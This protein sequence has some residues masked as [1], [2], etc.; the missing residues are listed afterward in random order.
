MIEETPIP[1][2]LVVQ[3]K[4]FEDD[5]GFFSETWNARAYSQAGIDVA[6]V[7]D[8]QS[9]S[10]RAGTLRGLHYQRPPFAQAK[11]VRCGRGRLFDV[12]VDVRQGSPTFGEWFGIEL[13]PDNGLQLFVPVGFLHGF[14]TLEPQTEILYKC[15]AHYS[16][17]HDGAVHYADPE[18]AIDWPLAGQEPSLSAKDAAAQGI[19]G[20]DNPFR[21]EEI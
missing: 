7:Q 17:P 20:F 16:Q 21:F 13:T 1:G 5:R 11:L 8:N 12:A 10:D 15:S 2:L 18:L 6:F 14:L 4:R 9:L 3:P 19:D